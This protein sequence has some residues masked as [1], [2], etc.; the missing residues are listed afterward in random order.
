[1]FSVR[2]C[3]SVRSRFCLTSVFTVMLCS[4]SLYACFY[5]PLGLRMHCVLSLHQLVCLCI[6]L[7]THHGMC[8]LPVS[9]RESV[10]NLSSSFGVR[11]SICAS[12]S[13]NYVPVTGSPRSILHICYWLSPCKSAFAFFLGGAYFPSDGVVTS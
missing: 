6:F 13:P 9:V 5:C 4:L 11:R 1:M 12:S 3:A 2:M 7:L 10:I 8:V